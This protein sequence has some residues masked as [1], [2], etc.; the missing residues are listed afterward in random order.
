[1]KTSAVDGA[2][3]GKGTGIVDVLYFLKERTKFIRE[4]YDSATGPFRETIRRIEAG[5]APFDQPPYSEDG[6]PPFMEQWA[7]A[8]KSIEVVGRM[9]ISMLSASLQLYF[10]TWKSE[11]GGKWQQKEREKAFKDGFVDGY[12]TCFGDVLNISWDDCPADFSLLE[13]VT[14]ARNRDQHPESI[15]SLRVNHSRKDREKY[16]RPFFI[17]QADDRIFSDPE[18]AAVAWMSPAVHVSRESLYAS[19]EEVEKLA[20]WLEPKMFAAKYR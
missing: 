15:T 13:Q 10:K 20:E 8:Q 3:A 11:F 18:M 7:K 6:E 4:F 19:I 12:R 2:P 14:L 17:S 9:C 5:D 1:L 16:L